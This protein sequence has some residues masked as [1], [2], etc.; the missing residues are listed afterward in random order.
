MNI[1]QGKKTNSGFRSY[2]LQT[3]Y[4]LEFPWIFQFKVILRLLPEQTQNS[5]IFRTR[6][7]LRTLSIYPVKF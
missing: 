6:A 4:F 3:S 2:A 5:G 1:V 7:M